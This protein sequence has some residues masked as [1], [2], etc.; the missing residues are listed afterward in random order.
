MYALVK[1]LKELYEHLC[2]QFVYLL[3]N[4]PFVQPISKSP[5]VI[6]KV[7]TPKQ[8][9]Y[10]LFVNGINGQRRGILLII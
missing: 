10:A 2:D 7:H 4:I 3:I 6:S 9:V 1:L 8:P 5:D